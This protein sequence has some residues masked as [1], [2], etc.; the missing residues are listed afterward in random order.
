MVPYKTLPLQWLLY[1]FRGGYG[2]N[3]ELSKVN[4]SIV[5]CGLQ[6]VKADVWPQEEEEMTVVNGGMLSGKRCSTPGSQH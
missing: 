2:E 5:L 3:I 4:E 6:L 1:P